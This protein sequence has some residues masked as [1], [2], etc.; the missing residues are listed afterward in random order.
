MFLMNMNKIDHSIEDNLGDYI[1]RNFLRIIVISVPSIA[2]I[3]EAKNINFI[4]ILG[5]I[6]AYVAVIFALFF[7]IRRKLKINPDMGMKS[8]GLVAI[9]LPDM[10]LIFLALGILISINSINETP[11]IFVLATILVPIG[12]YYRWQLMKKQAV[13]KRGRK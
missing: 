13:R 4:S 7:L 5:W 11:W 12:S 9:I 2:I 3:L 1:T 6:F 8:L 10:I